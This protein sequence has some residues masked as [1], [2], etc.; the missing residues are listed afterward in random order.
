VF[1]VERHE[2]HLSLR[3]EIALLDCELL[4]YGDWPLQYSSSKVLRQCD[5][6]G[7]LQTQYGI[8]WV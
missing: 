4:A 6:L 7:E 5:S 8:C 2:F 3:G 1:D